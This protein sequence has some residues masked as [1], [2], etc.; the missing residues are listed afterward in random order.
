MTST[1]STAAN[2]VAPRQPRITAINLVR[3]FVISLVISTHIAA[4]GPLYNSY[5]AGGVWIISHV[6]RLLFVALT[7]IVLTY[8]YGPDR[9]FKVKSFYLK[10]FY[11]IFLPYATWSLLY[12]IQDG[13]VQSSLGDFIRVYLFDLVTAQAMYHLYFLLVSMQIY[14]L[15]PL[16]RYFYDK[17]RHRPAQLFT[18]SLLL[19]LL[20]TSL[21]QYVKPVPGLEWYWQHPENY[22][23][24]YQFYIVC[25][26]L[27]A[28]HIT[29]LAAQL[30]RHFKGIKWATIMATFMSL[31]LYV[32][33]THMGL[34]PNVAAAVYQPFLVLTSIV[35]GL[36]V[37][38]LGFRWV[39]S[40]ERFAPWIDSIAEDSFGIYLSHPFVILLL[41]RVQPNH[42]DIF[43]GILILS[44]GLP[45][46]YLS[47]FVFSELARRT[48]LSLLLTG[49]R[50]VPI[51]LL[52]RY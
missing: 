26:M 46:V 15:F 4:S 17:V 9:P 3:L 32:F 20:I 25:G 2:V 1:Q 29:A 22:I 48:P 43:T 51:T 31:A 28:T 7:A 38:A 12:Q 13:V 40:G 42:N 52:K 16:L 5:F 19:Q 18:V 39:Q 36:F 10:R 8:N 21:L 23:W 50:R 33:E 27:V 37:F 44:V 49:R 47:A 45:I 30:K 35:Y 34:E 24:T 11:L 14:L 41:S 6:S